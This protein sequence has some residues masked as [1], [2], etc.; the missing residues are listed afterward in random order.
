MIRIDEVGLL[1]SPKNFMMR[2]LFLFKNVISDLISSNSES[3]VLRSFPTIKN[4][5]LYQALLQTDR[6]TYDKLIRVGNVFVSYDSCVCM[7][8]SK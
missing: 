6:V 5:N 8:V 2:L 4:S 7:M 1:V 3:K